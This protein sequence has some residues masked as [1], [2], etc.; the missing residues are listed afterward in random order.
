MTRPSLVLLVVA[1]TLPA[2]A[3]PAKPWWDG[4]ARADFKV[5]GCIVSVI[6]P[7]SPAAGNPWVWNAEFFGHRPNVDQAL[8]AQGFHVAYVTVGNTFGCPDAMKH[9][10]AAYDE[11]RSRYHLSAKPAFEALSRGGLYAYHWAAKH[12]DAVSCIYAD[13]PVCDIKSWP[14]GK[15]KGKGSPNDWKKLIGDYHFKDEDEALAYDNNPVDDK[16][17]KPLAEHKVPLLHVVGDADDVV[18]VEENTALVEKRYKDLGGEITVI[19]KPGVNHHPHGLDDPTP[20]VEFI[21][22]AQSKTTKQ[23]EGG[24]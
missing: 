22:R 7:K 9:W 5:D 21:I 11:L 19:H 13:A 23:A 2:S 1:L 8:L 24:S 18:P 10:N 17:L 3:Q 4:Y 20:I 6:A 12:P 15:G 16:V 14:A